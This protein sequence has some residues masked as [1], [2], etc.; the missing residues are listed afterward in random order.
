MAY[1]RIICSGGLLLLLIL[2]ALGLAACDLS[3]DGEN[4]GFVHIEEGSTETPLA[5]TAEAEAH[6]SVTP[7]SSP[8][9]LP[10]NEPYIIPTSDPDVD[11]DM[12]ITR[13]G[14]E[15]ITLSAYQKQ[16]R[17]ERWFRLYQLAGLVEKHGADQILDLRK[18]ENA[19]VSSLFATLADSVT[20]GEQVQ[21]IMI[22]DKIAQQEAL[23]R[24]V[25]LDP[26]Q[27]DAKLVQYLTLQLGEGA[28]LPPEFD[29]RYADFLA[30]M[31]IYT[32]MTEEE[33]RR[34]VRARTLYTQ[35]EFIIS[36]QPEA[37]QAAENAPAGVEVQDIVVE[38]EE[39]ARDVISRL[40]TG[41]TMREIAVSL[42]FVPND[43]I[44][45][46][47]VRAGDT[48][49]PEDVLNALLSAS[50][51]AIIGPMATEYGWYVAV[52]GEPVMDI[53]SPDEISALKKR[54]FLDW[55]EALMDDPDYV[56][57]LNNWHDY[58]PQEPLPQDVSPLLRDENV[59]LP[60]E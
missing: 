30:S 10:T 24:G 47:T 27:F 2:M 55:V 35:L 32:G 12:V 22:I 6:P 34:I 36:N 3:D 26:Y 13:V 21:R 19:Q 25:E 20:F 11:Q 9:P 56:E 28:Q 18:Q 48:A 44:E 57:D 46:R 5:L 45:W 31:A 17:F 42:G 16:V 29:E 23:R 40:Q 37:I 15:T 33:F 43:D 58:I 1:R 41:E 60:E 14:N 7:G 38:T 51:G 53:L 49:L 59:I 39:S 4:Q 50:A 54:Y 8:T 52:I